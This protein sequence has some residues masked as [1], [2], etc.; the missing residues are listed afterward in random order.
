MSLTPKTLRTLCGSFVLVGLVLGGILISMHLTDRAEEQK[1]LQDQQQ[2]EAGSGAMGVLVTKEESQ[3][4]SSRKLTKKR[5]LQFSLI[6]I[7]YGAWAGI[8]ARRKEGTEP[9]SADS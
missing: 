1:R 3:A 4:S 9:P 2:V 8:H 6:F 5:L 7:V